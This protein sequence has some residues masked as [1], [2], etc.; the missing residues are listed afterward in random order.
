MDGDVGH[1]AL[2]GLFSPVRRLQPFDPRDVLVMVFCW[3]RSEGEGLYPVQGDGVFPGPGGQGVY[4]W[5]PWHCAQV[6]VARYGGGR[7]WLAEA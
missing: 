4:A 1:S 5:V 6:H 3:G 2:V 7:E